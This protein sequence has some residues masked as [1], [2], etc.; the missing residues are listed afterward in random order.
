MDLF[1]WK[2]PSSNF[3]FWWLTLLLSSSSSS[4][5]RSKRSSG[6]PVLAA[7]TAVLPQQIPLGDFPPQRMGQEGKEHPAH[8]VLLPLLRRRRRRRRVLLAL[9]RL[10]RRLP[11]RLL[12]P[13]RRF[14]L[15]R[16][17]QQRNPQSAPPSSHR[18]LST[19]PPLPSHQQL[20][21]S[22]T[23]HNHPIPS[24]HRLPLSPRSS[25]ERRRRL[26]FL[27]VGSLPVIGPPIGPSRAETH[28]GRAAHR[29]TQRGRRGVL[30]RRRIR[31]HLGRSSRS[32]GTEEEVGPDSGAGAGVGVGAPRRRSFFRDGGG[33]ALPG[34]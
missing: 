10:P 34:R 22:R 6:V 1:S 30:S 23:V 7:A 18:R 2:A 16:R 25:R 20:E 9:G 5:R 14:V 33:G 13:Q 11:K 17:E 19:R 4:R 27:G 26:L 29:G 8:V 31:C 21:P 28:Q 3:L 12:Q 15:G 32:G 24:M